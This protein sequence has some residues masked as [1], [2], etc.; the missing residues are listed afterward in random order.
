MILNIVIALNVAGIIFAAALY[1]RITYLEE[2]ADKEDFRFLGSI[3]PV[4]FS[5][6]T[7][8]NSRRLDGF[9]GQGMS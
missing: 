1:A 3:D 6:T 9:E 4:S 2:R 8:P 5:F 7:E